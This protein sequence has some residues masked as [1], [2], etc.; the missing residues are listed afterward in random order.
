MVAT[1]ASQDVGS[2]KVVPLQVTGD[3]AARFSLVVLGDG[4]TA[5]EIP[6]FRAQVDKHL[7]VLWSIEPFRSY[8]SYI[9]VY[10]VEIVSGES[11][12]TCD[13][14]I[15]QKKNTPLRTAF[16]GGCTNPNARGINV[17]EAAAK[18]FASRAT[19][20]FDQILV[21]ANTDT[22]GGIGGRVATTSGGNSLGPLITPH[23]IGHSLGGLRDEYTYSARGKPGGPYTG[24]EPNSI[25]LTLLTEAQ[26]Q[27]RQQ[28]WWRWV[29]EISESGGPIGRFEGGGSRTTGIWRPSKHSMMI[30][31]GYYFDQVSRERMTQR[32]SEQVA[33]IAAST[34]A[35]EPVGPRDVI[36]IETAQPVYHDLRVTWHADGKVVEAANDSRYLNLANLGTARPSSVTVTVTDPTEFVRDPDIKAGALTATRTWK[37]GSRGSRSRDARVA[38]TSSSQTERPV[39][40][41]DV[42]SVVTT[43]PRDRVPDVVWRLNGNVVPHG[44]NNRALSLA[45]L[46]LPRGTHKLSATI[47]DPRSPRSVQTREWV[48]DNTGPVVTYLLATPAAPVGSGE[49]ERHYFV[50]DEFTMKLDASDD[51]PGYVVAEFRVNGDGWHHYYGWPDA[52]TGTPFKFTSRGTTIKELVYGSL[53][54]EGLS[55][56]PWEPREPGWGTHRIEYRGIDA[57]GNIGAAKAFRVTILPAPSCNMTITAPHSGEL[58]VNE[59]VFCVNGATVSGT[60]TVLPGASLIAVDARFNG[61]IA[62]SGGARIELINS[63]IGDLRIEG[64]TDSVTLFGSTV[65]GRVTLSDNR[66]RRPVQMIGNTFRGAVACSGNN[67]SPEDGGTANTFEVGAAGQCAR[68]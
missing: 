37:V 50:R 32:I 59:G 54:A 34:P 41:R 38:F 53:S 33:L 35:D 11:G 52:P 5:A 49:A 65:T 61:T 4:Y 6:K 17:D 66:T 62:A 64:A 19:P 36:W 9:N 22:Y 25:H 24:E 43:Y 27:Q 14:E 13:P 39:G 15:R 26:M 42:I 60:V 21:L 58:Q 3:P 10:A 1:G 30:S 51:Q 68:R 46:D 57:A 12:I 7:N 8:R 29:G 31:I 63:T 45:R 48:V 56:Q 44:S 23:E 20:H 55:P 67:A 40:G 16:G 2:A 28:K 18:S 47:S